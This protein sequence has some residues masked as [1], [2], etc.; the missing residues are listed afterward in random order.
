MRSTH[1]RSRSGWPAQAFRQTC[2]RYASAMHDQNQEIADWLMRLTDT[3]R[4]WGF[5]RCFLYLRNVIDDFSR[6]A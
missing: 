5:G 6:E 3:Y 2:D 1:A 4:T